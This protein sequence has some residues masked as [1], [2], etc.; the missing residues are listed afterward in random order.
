MDI[1]FIMKYDNKLFLV[2][3]KKCLDL[4]SSVLAD[5]SFL[6]IVTPFI[7]GIMLFL[8]WE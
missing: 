5:F 2:I 4:S 3:E 8:I 7:P 6:K 1:N